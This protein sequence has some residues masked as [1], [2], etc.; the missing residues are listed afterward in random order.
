MAT[1]KRTGCMLVVVLLLGGGAWYFYLRKA[2]LTLDSQ[3]PVGLQAEFIL[4]FD[5]T[6]PAETNH[7][8][9]FNVDPKG[10]PYLLIGRT[11]IAAKHSA[12]SEA[13]LIPLL[14]FEPIRDF[15]TIS[16]FEM[17]GDFA[18]MRDGSLLLIEGTRLMVLTRE[19][20]KSVQELPQAGMKLAPAS[21]NECY[22]FGGETLEQQRNLYLYRK[23]GGL[24]HLMQA[25]SPIATAAGTGELT[26]VAINDAIYVLS[27]ANTLT[28]VLQANDPVTS[29]A[30]GPD[31][32][33]FFST[34]KGVGFS[35]GSNR[36]FLFVNGQGAEIQVRDEMLYLFFPK[37]GI[38]K[39]SPASLFLKTSEVN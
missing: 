22:L 9:I 3:F 14:D 18:W 20:M 28:L 8:G 13:E 15:K 30:I 29:L 24:L 21:E 6:T 12:D 16:D 37:I 7:R 1:V 5:E 39:C 11:L 23:R 10:R 27:P 17:I 32:S 34:S 31:F 25:E 35:S 4:K 36:G 26:F 2:P 38:M 19:G 33:L